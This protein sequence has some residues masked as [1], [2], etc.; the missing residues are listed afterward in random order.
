[1]GRRLGMDFEGVDGW[2]MY[3]GQRIP[4]FPRHPHRGFETVT[5]AR[6]GFI[7]HSDSLGASARFG[8][9]DLQWMT[10]GRG[11]VHSE[12]FPLLRGDAD[13]P[14]EL[15][16][17]WLN[18]PSDAKMTAPFFTMFWDHQ[19]PKRFF[20]DGAGRSTQV[21]LYT[22][23]L[24][25]FDVPPAPPQGSWAA[26]PGSHVVIA[27]VVL[28][29]GAQW[30]L[31]SAYGGVER[32]LYAFAGESLRVDDVL[33][34][35]P[36]AFTIADAEPCLLQNQSQSEPAEVLLLQGCPIGEPVAHHGPFVMN[37]MEELRQ[38]FED[39]RRTDFGGWPWDGDDPVHPR[40]TGRFALHADGRRETP[41]DLSGSR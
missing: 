4:G 41:E 36:S 19:I 38:A 17:I 22:G 29:P 21:A 37:T 5:I 2:R 28:E 33:A 35:L 23:M 27:S 32:T 14:T 1:M 10:A 40:D 3:H 31:P 9:G 6:Q 7:D 30:E 15:F 39:F 12:M 25:G 34:T 24:D 18:L 16:Q 8:H 20:V 11:V 13:N 26:R